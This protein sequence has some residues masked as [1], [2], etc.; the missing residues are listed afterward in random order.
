MVFYHLVGLQ[1][2]DLVHLIYLQHKTQLSQTYNDPRSAPNYVT[3]YYPTTA[4]YLWAP[5]MTLT[6]GQSYDFSFYW[7]GDATS[8]WVGDVLVNNSPSAT[9]A[10]NLN[11]FVTQTTTTTNA[12]TKVTVTFVPATTGSY[13]FGI[14][15]FSATTA[16]YYMG[17]DD[18]QCTIN[19]S[20]CRAYLCCSKFYYNLLQ[21]RCLGMRQQQHQQTDMFMH[22][23]QLILR[24]LLELLLLLHRYHFLS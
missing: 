1:Q 8:G 20:L 22:I 15:S 7:A 10:T 2:E 21:Q 19:T 9:G 5:A 17:F 6:A 16:P 11:T 12:Y 3:I 4:A 24:L 13:N 23:Q 14:K 18:F